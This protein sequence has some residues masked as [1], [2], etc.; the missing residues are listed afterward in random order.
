MIGAEVSTWSRGNEHTL[1]SRG[2]IYDFI[3]SANMMW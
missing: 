2:K 3:Y 1:G